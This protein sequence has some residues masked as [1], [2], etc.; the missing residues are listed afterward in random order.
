MSTVIRPYA[1]DSGKAISHVAFSLVL[2]IAILTM[3]VP[4]LAQGSPAQHPTELRELWGKEYADAQQAADSA[5][6]L[7]AAFETR[8]SLHPSSRLKPS[9]KEAKQDAE[10]VIAAYAH[11]ADSYPN[12]AI[13]ARSGIRLAGFYQYLGQTARAIDMAK[14]VASI[15]ENTQ[16]APRAAFEVG[17]LYFQA[18][19][20]PTAA[21]EWFRKVPQPKDGPIEAKDYGEGAK[22]YLAAQQ[23]IA[24]CAL[25]MGKRDIAQDRFS[26][27]AEQYPMYRDAI[28]AER[29]V[30]SKT[31]LHPGLRLVDEI[32]DQRISD[33]GLT[34][35]PPSP[36]D[37]A[38]QPPSPA[39]SDRSPR[40]AAERSI[41]YPEKGNSWRYWAGWSLLLL[42]IAL[43]ASGVF[44]RLRTRQRKG[45]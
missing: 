37:S 20:N 16:Y 36:V 7:R 45:D 9:S 18:A 32:I 34:A 4:S 2:G 19:H 29:D 8:Y 30:H 24:R 10:K 15:Y 3:P 22:L 13:A 5:D 31:S 23:Q 40:I 12:T 41:T 35:V 38:T 6:R 33:L 44:Y 21:M 25:S 1:A 11:V 43:S 14:E 42:G 27:L 39:P 28:E 26:R 17:L